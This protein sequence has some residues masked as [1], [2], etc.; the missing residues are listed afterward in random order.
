MS[1]DKPQ[2]FRVVAGASIKRVAAKDDSRDVEQIVC[3]VCEIDIGVATSTFSEVH[4]SPHEQIGEIVRSTKGLV[5]TYCLARGK[6]T[7]AL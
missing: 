1:D 5:C 2:R 3:R 4:L 6:V 7:R